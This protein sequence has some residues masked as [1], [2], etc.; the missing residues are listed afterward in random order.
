MR[1]EERQAERSENESKKC[2]R[3]GRDKQDVE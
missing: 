3:D 1:E 2:R